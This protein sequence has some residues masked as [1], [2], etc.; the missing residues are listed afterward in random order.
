[1]REE[2]R[3][4]I[5]KG[6]LEGNMLIRRCRKGIRQREGENISECKG[7]VKEEEDREG[8][9]GSPVFLPLVLR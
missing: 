1:M 7:K 8:H 3:R 5:D 2:E 6:G 9:I 4:Q